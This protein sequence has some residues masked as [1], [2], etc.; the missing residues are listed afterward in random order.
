MQV[1]LTNS[2]SGKDDVC[3]AKVWY[4]C[5]DHLP[6]D[7]WQ[8]RNPV[9]VYDQ[10]GVLDRQKELDASDTVSPEEYE[11]VAT[12]N[13]KSIENRRMKSWKENT[14]L[15]DFEYYKKAYDALENKNNYMGVIPD[16]S[17]FFN[18]DEGEDLYSEE[19]EEYFLKMQEDVSKLLK[20]IKD[21][22][23]STE[24]HTFF[25]SLN[26]IAVLRSRALLAQ[27]WNI[28]KRRKARAEA[29]AQETD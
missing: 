15:E 1:K 27:S 13:A 19:A 25:G 20:D 26:T 14:P 8:V 2:K 6:K 10:F 18:H 22:G 4:N 23:V 29:Q 17:I 3:K 16:S 24:I 9:I 12:H 7:G 5:N 11:R 21:S 28:E